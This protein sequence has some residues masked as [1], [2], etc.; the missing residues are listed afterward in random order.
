MIAVCATI[1]VLIPSLALAS[2]EGGE[3]IG[4]TLG[5]Y[6]VIPFACML[7]S[8]AIFPL[9]K[10]EFWEHHR[11]KVAI[12]WSLT[13]LVPFAIVYGFQHAAYELLEVIVNDYLSFIVLLFSLFAVAG[14]ITLRG[15]L[16]GTTKVNVVLILIGTILSSWIGTTGASMLMIRP[17]LK[18]NAWRKKKAHI[19]VFFIFLVSNIGGCLTPVGDPPLF[20]GFLRGVPF[21]WTTVHL[22][23]ELILNVVI[24]LAVFIIMDRRYYKKEIAAGNCPP[25]TKD[26]KFAKE[27]L[28][29][30]GLHNIIFLAMIV[31]SVILCGLIPSIPAFCDPDGAVKGIRIIME[32][33]ELPVNYLIQIIIM[34]IAAFL[35]MKTTKKTIREANHFTWEPIKEVA[36]LFIGIFITMIPALLYLTAHGPELGLTS[37][38][39]FFWCT[40]ALSSFLDNAP[41]Y[42]VF[43]TTA[44]A[45]GATEGIATSVGMIPVHLLA[46]VS[47]G[48]VFMG[49]NTYIGNAPN[50]MVRSIAE[51]NKVKMPSFFGYMAWSLSILIPVFIIDTII[52]YL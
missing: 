46:A 31:G 29:I 19:V 9:V 41:T 20:L 27:P 33:I 8:I 51:E 21:F 13:F 42:L 3:D 38:W 39:Q 24:L 18:A 26:P 11:F 44:G 45:L 4:S 28:K 35:S 22:L 17:L 32:G 34:L 36:Q 40:G 43:M 23:P 5:L 30:E 37:A 2:P 48:A 12:F 14:G 49:A 15:T 7:L 16:V 25:D 50:F 1:L 47:S 6:W 52:F 10:P